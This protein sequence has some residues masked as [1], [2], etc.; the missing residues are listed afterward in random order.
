[1]SLHT[2]LR[3]ACPLSGKVASVPY[4]Q[5]NGEPEII[6]PEEE[7]LLPRGWGRLTL[8]VVIDNPE[9]DAARKARAAFIAEQLAATEELLAS[10]AVPDAEKARLQKAVKSGE[11]AQAIEQKADEDFPIPDAP[12]VIL[13]YAYEALSNDAMGTAFT[14]LEAAGF[15]FQKVP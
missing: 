6:E 14:A 5:V 4:E 9:I 7:L 12:K 13:R 1:M 3:I 2:V 8:D 10:D 15:V 11:L